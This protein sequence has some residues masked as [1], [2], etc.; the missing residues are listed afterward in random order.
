MKTPTAPRNYPADNPSFRRRWRPA[1]PLLPVG[2]I[3]G[4]LTQDLAG[5][6]VRH[7]L[8]RAEEYGD[9]RRTACLAAAAAIA[10]KAGLDEAN[11]ETERAA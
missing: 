4:E 7:W 6:A 3:A 5:R 1:G 8:R 11:L 10:R 9:E 2:D